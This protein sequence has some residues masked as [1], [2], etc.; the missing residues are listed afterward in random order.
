MDH[1]TEWITQRDRV[2]YTEIATIQT[3][4]MPPK[5][6]VKSRNSIEQEGRILLAI[7]AFEK[8]EICSI[9]QAAA[10]Y[11][12]PFSSLRNRLHGRITRAEQRANGHKLSIT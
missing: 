1:P 7:S 4:A 6:R 12:V 8:Q 5:S 11:R 9:R 2:C 10:H 3:T